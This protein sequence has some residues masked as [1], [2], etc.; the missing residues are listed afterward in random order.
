M[1]PKLEQGDI[2][3]IVDESHP[4]YGCILVV[5]EPKN[6]G[7]QGFLEY[8]TSNEGDGKHVSIWLRPTTDQIRLVGHVVLGFIN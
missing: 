8:P 7:M 3:Q 5:D 6:W 2:V 4:W 1:E